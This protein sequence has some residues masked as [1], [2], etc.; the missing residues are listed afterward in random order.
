[1]ICGVQINQAR[2]YQKKNGFWE[3]WIIYI[4]R[5]DELAIVKIKVIKR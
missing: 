2:E 5:R 4:Y 3:N 1:M